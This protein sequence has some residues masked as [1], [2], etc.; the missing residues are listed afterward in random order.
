MS[1]TAIELLDPRILWSYYLN[2]LVNYE[3]NS[4]V[5]KIASFCRVL[6]ILISLPIIILG[7]LDV[8]SYLIA[9]T[10]G[11]IDDVKASTSDTATLHNT[12]Q[13]VPSIHI[14]ASSP[15]RDS[16]Q[17]SDLQSPPEAPDASIPH[18]FYASEEQD[19]KLSGV[20]VFS[21]AASRPPSPTITRKELSQDNG[22]GIRQRVKPG[23]T[24][25]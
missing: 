15:S 4:A 24:Q 16:S 17:Y 8:S 19:L 12:A 22:E 11:V 5:A 3:P 7:L 9:R 18:P 10:L 1:I 20:G 21:P 6:A 25:A 23:S 13:A 14:E 2:Y